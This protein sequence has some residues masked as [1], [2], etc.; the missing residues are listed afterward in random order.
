MPDATREPDQER[1]S[2]VGSIGRDETRLEVGADDDWEERWPRLQRIAWMAIA[3]ILLLGIGGLFGRGPVDHATAAAPDGAFTVDY[4]P[5][6]RFRT[7]SVI[8]LHF[9]PELADDN[10][11]V[12]IQGNR[13]LLAPPQ[14][15]RSTPQPQVWKAGPDGPVMEFRVSRSDA[16]ATIALDVEPGAVGFYLVEF[17]ATNL[18]PVS[19]HQ[20]VLP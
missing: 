14:I 5:V 6:V 11:V 17:A 2:S 12:S 10:S 16:E 9:S 13:N 3:I 7:S 8:T 4:E 15:L 20:L 19:L 18:K 1:I